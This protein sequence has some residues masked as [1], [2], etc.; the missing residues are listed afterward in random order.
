MS[1]DYNF[2]L[3]HEVMRLLLCNGLCLHYF[4]FYMIFVQFKCL[5]REYILF[6]VSVSGNSVLL[7]SK[8]AK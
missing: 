7:R 1:C 3:A 8:R 2:V 5:E 4:N 6:L